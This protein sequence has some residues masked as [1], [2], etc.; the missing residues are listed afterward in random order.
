MDQNTV[1]SRANQAAGAAQDAMGS[2]LNNAE[3]SRDG[4]FDMAKNRPVT[5]AASAV[6]VGDTLRALAHGRRA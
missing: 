1:D 5:T 4:V 6:A 3:R 2:T